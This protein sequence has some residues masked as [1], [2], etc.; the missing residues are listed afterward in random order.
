MPRRQDGRESP[1]MNHEGSKTRRTL[2]VFFEP[3]RP[4]CIEDSPEP[5]SRADQSPS[6]TAR[7]S[8]PS[9]LA[10]PHVVAASWQKRRVL[11]ADALERLIVLRV[12]HRIRAQNVDVMRQF[13][14][15]LFELNGLRRSAC[16]PQA[17][18]TFPAKSDA[19]MCFPGLAAAAR[20]PLIASRNRTGSVRRQHPMKG[21]SRAQWR[22]RCPHPA[23]ATP[24]EGV[25][26]EPPLPR[27]SRHRRR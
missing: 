26:G 22:H 11:R 27:R 6:G 7:A 12:R 25:S 15:E 1:D 17:S 9:V 24:A 14:T 19:G 13:A 2:V 16:G 23:R 10:P 3:S 5:I 4:G 18:C 8:S 21:R 20:T